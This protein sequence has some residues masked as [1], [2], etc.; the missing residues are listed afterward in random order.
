M[1]V[2]EV[3]SRV[4]GV[5]RRLLAH[6]YVEAIAR[7]V[8]TYREERT[9]SRLI[10]DGLLTLAATAIAAVAVFILLKLTGALIRIVE[11]RY[12]GSLESIE[13]KS[14]SLI[15][16]KAIW[17]VAARI[18]MSGGVVAGILVLYFYLQF[19]LNLYP[20]TRGA[21][22]YL[23]IVV[24][25]PFLG[26]ATNIL[27]SIPDLIV[28]VIIAFVTKYLLTLARRF[29]EAIEQGQINFTGFEV[30]WVS[31]TLKIVRILI[32][33][34]AVVIA[35]PYIP[36]SGSEAFK[37]VTIFVGVLFS[38]GS[39]SFVANLIAGYTMTYRR[40][41]RVGDRIAIGDAIGVVTHM[42][43]MATHLRSVKNE[44]IIIPNS[45]I[46]TSEVTNFS[47][48]AREKGVIL[49]TTVGIGYDT[50]WR[51]VEAMLLMAAGRTAGILRDPPP[52]VRQKSLGDFS[53]TYE[54]NVYCNRPLEMDQIY[55]E[56][57]HAIL[58]VFNEYKVP[59][60]TPAYEGD[61][62][63]PKIVPKDRWF[64]APA[65]R[66]K[67]SSP[68]SLVG[69]ADVAGGSPKAGSF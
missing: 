39:S 65:L 64:A 26:I 67:E 36:G 5:D 47:S 59:I 15:S 37:G 14:Y 21:A 63:A 40:T 28:I 57:H 58:D 6:T 1:T 50:P 43:S 68:G 8:T 31:P 22:E 13:A 33:A 20:W 46:L 51:Q 16:A 7:A 4:E 55:G 12:Q 23:A 35:Y 27:T 38:L 11:R 66:T 53:V 52:Y 18:L 54:L 42:R 32:I 56:L 45:T 30:A 9:P 3:D 61:P 60:M 25:N 62:V 10:H 29:F 19:V 2:F 17:N 34:F 48:F 69:E 44:E 24:L 41:F 49:H